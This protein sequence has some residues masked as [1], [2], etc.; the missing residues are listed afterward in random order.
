MLSD[1]VKNALSRFPSQEISAAQLAREIFKQ[2]PK[3]AKG[4]ATSV[5][6]VDTAEKLPAEKWLDEIRP[7]FDFSALEKSAKPERIESAS[8]RDESANSKQAYE[9][10]KLNENMNETIQL[11]GRLVIIGL[12]LLD[13]QLRRQLERQGVLSDLIE[14]L[15]EPL[16][17]ILTQRGRM[18]YEL[19]DSV[20][21]W[22]DNEMNDPKKDLLGR[23]AFADYLFARIS[24]L[25]KD[26]EAYV[27]HLYG[28]WG[29][30]KSTVLK[31]LG[32]KL[33]NS[34]LWLVVDYNAWQNQHIDPPW[35][36]LMDG[37]F[38][39]LKKQHPGQSRME[40]YW[41][42]IKL[43]WWK[44][45]EYLWRFGTGHMPYIIGF[46]VLLWILVIV[47]AVLPYGSKKPENDMLVFLGTE[48]DNIGKILAVIATIWG[49]VIAANRSLFLGSSQAAREYVRLTSDPMLK[50]KNHLEE[51]IKWL[52]PMRLAI[53]IDDLDRCQAG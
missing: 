30:G 50:V 15:H 2:H 27:M 20:P 52:V 45:R 32:Q 44:M 17:K 48:F 35:W 29:S 24:M 46:I 6:I 38:Q 42:R 7:L 26:S 21:N 37:I 39:S 28:P 11:H 8:Y 5:S 36:S 49:F 41:W 13:V 14:E 47:V 25:P 31:F 3:Y 53:L 18:L 34:G 33:E 40:K 51:S 9:A 19:Q 43:Y 1:S 16:D 10:P 4:G 23:A 22:D 12:C